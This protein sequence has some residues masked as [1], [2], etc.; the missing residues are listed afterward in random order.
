VGGGE[1]K[2]ARGP[3]GQRA[4]AGRSFRANCIKCAGRATKYMVG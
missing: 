1:E 4:R 3:E 2:G